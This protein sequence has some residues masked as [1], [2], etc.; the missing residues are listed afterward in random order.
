MKSWATI[1]I[2]QE[3]LNPI[4]SLNRSDVDKLYVRLWQSPFKK[5]L[6]FLTKQLVNVLDSNQAD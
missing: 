6:F 5:D 1:L 2:V 4:T 3:I